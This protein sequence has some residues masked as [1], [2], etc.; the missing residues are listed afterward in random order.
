MSITHAYT[1]AAA[2]LNNGDALFIKRRIEIPIVSLHE[3]M[4][5]C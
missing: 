5:K 1:R 4:V 2:V 3:V